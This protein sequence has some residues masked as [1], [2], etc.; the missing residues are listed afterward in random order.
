[1]T[2]G[3]RD[4]LSQRF[5]VSFVSKEISLLGEFFFKIL[6]KRKIVDF[7]DFLPFSETKVIKLCTSKPTH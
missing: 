6:K 3:W 2:L 4:R 5:S 7:R 1:M